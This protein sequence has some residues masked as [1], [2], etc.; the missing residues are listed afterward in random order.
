M[1]ELLVKTF[2]RLL[3]SLGCVALFVALARQDIWIAVSKF[4]YRP[5]MS[6]T[7]I[8]STAG[9]KNSQTRKKGI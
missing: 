2:K 1:P 5:S 8:A 4:T 3:E 9:N 7:T 6:K